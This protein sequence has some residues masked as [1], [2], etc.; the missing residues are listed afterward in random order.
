MA[1]AT[2]ISARPHSPG[3]AGMSAFRA[4][5]RGEIV[6]PGDVDYDEARG[7]WNP[8][9]DRRPALIVRPADAQ[10]VAAA[11]RFARAVGLELA[12]RSGGHS[13]AGHSTT[14]GGLLVDLGR[15]RGLHIDPDARTVWAEAGLTAGEL[16]SAAHEHGLAVPFGDTGS[17][18]IGGITLGGGIGWLG[19]KHGL[20]VDSLL[21]AEI[22][23]ADGEI[24]TVSQS[25]QPDLFWAIRGGGGNFGIVTRFQYRL[26]PVG[27]VLGGALALP[28]TADV[29]TGLVEAADAAPDELTTIS[30]VMP[31]PPAPFV[32]ADQHGRTALIVMPVFAG[33]IDAGQAA[34]APFRALATPIA[35]VVGPMPYPAMY[36]LT[37]EGSA[38][39][40][41]TGWSTFADALPHDIADQIVRRMS[42]PIA[43]HAM[44]QIRVLGGAISR[45]PADAT[46]FAHRDRRLAFMVNAA[47][48]DPSQADDAERWVE[49]MATVLQPV[50]NGVYANF[51]GDEGHARVREAYP[52]ETYQRLA[53]IKRRY[54]PSNLFRLNQNIDPA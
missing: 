47:Y 21:A 39:H 31:L 37:A 14:D 52:S 13:V 2:P 32:P 48:G 53:A 30:F 35:D 29:L 18:G 38:R 43:G 40:P 34:M 11:I 33:D 46:A 44:L 7:A 1:L 36:Q 25:R 24:Q 45:V 26:H 6:Q 8:A 3:D 27:L 54:D 17:V 42:A 23:T 4:R 9:F 50:A 5:F 12:V 19:R 16:T 41:N 22:V 20:T 10:D 51:V 15:L 28:L 49:Q